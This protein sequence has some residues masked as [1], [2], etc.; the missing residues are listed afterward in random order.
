MT[1]RSIIDYNKN[2]DDINIT[3]CFVKFKGK[4]VYKVE[5]DGFTLSL[6]RKI[7]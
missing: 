6:I 7:N 2:N 3:N 1:N 4:D 5:R